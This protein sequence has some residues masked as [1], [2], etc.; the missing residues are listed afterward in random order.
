MQ[1]GKT[2]KDVLQ[3]K[4]EKLLQQDAELQRIT[5]EAQREMQRKEQS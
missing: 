2:S 1:A 3:K 4:Y 5:V